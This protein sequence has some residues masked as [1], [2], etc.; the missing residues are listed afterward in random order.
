MP[1]AALY[2]RSS[3]DRSD[4]SI[5][6]QRSELGRLAKARQLNLVAEYVDAVESGKDEDRPG[7]QQLLSA[8]R[9]PRRGWDTVLVL[10]TSRIARR[11]HIAIMFEH[12]CQRR[13][14]RI[15]YKSVPESDPITEMLLKS[16]LQ[17]MDEWH[18]MTSRMKGLSGMAENVRKGWRAG[19]RAPFGYRLEHVE[20]ATLR[21]GVPVRKS[22]LVLSAD[23]NAVQA[24]LQARAAGTPRA[25]AG[26]AGISP[27][28]LVGIEWNAL[29]YAGHTVWNVHAEA[30]SG[31]KRRPRAEWLVKPDTHPALITQAEADAILQRLEA[32][33]QSR[34]RTRDAHYLLTGLLVTP[35]GTRFHGD[36]GAYRVKGRQVQAAAVDTLVAKSV[37]RDLQ[38]PSFVKAVTKAA[39]A[40]RSPTTDATLQEEL[41]SAERRLARIMGLLEH[42]DAPAPLLRQMESLETERARLSDAVAEQEA[43]AARRSA[44]SRITEMEV[45]R[46]LVEQAARIEE[47]D[48]AL[49]RD[50]LE[51]LLT[52]VELD[53]KELTIHY[54]IGRDKL[55]SPR[56]AEPIPLAM[57][58]RLAG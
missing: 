2:C 14:V 4:V 17:A 28:S 20:T 45:R 55:A 42:T 38:S 31:R 10:D 29:T 30:G 32:Y 5:A 19:G 33:S 15:V 44:M 25:R 56:G 54:R 50:A 26:L 49:L 12:E 13:G 41:R 24:Y 40:L 52:R 16:I 36:R 7:F 48:P 9:N 37:L 27:A 43:E 51:S 11:R 1:T 6:A 3:K 46:L 47:A 39:R 35:D 23:A 8:I 57:V 53:G 22:R 34:P 58:Y 18:S 21:E